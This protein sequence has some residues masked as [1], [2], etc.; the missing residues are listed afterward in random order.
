VLQYVVHVYNIILS[1]AR[2]DSFVCASL[3]YV[4][5]CCSMLQCVTVCCSV[6][7]YVGCSVLQCVVDVYNIILSFARRELFVCLH[8]S[9]MCVT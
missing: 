1:F 7:Q 3:Q 5:V 9:F 2:R 4:A 6:L 8:D